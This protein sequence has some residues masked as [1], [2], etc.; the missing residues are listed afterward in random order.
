M[1]K[2]KFL[3]K[4]NK[5]FFL[6]PVY[7]VHAKRNL[8]FYLWTTNQETIKPDYQYCSQRSWIK[9][10]GGEG[11]VVAVAVEKKWMKIYESFQISTLLSF[12]KAQTW[13]TLK[14][15]LLKIV[16]NS[17]ACCPP[18]SLPHFKIAYEPSKEILLTLNK[19]GFCF[20]AMKQNVI[21]KKIKI[22]NFKL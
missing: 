10:G 5:N 20:E 1:N 15:S 18:L 22:F 6:V 2:K 11:K 7:T 3:F 9:F 14:F 16:L 13:H 4:I 19:N 17:F 12:Y 8:P 21:L